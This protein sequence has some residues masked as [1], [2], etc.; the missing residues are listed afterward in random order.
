[1]SGTDK[2]AIYV[3]NVGTIF[4]YSNMQLLRQLSIIRQCLNTIRTS[5][6]YDLPNMC[7][8]VNWCHLSATNKTLCHQDELQ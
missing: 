7:T 1:M 5:I 3:H 8:V 6:E 4:R 2:Q